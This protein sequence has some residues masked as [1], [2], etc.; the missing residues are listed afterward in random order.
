MNINNSIYGT[1]NESAPSDIVRTVV[2]KI[3]ESSH[4]PITKQDITLMFESLSS[5]LSSATE[6]ESV[7]ILEKLKEKFD[8]QKLEKTLPLL[9]PFLLWIFQKALD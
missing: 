3:N 4:D 6:G 1:V 5:L 8:I 2:E 9:S 7:G